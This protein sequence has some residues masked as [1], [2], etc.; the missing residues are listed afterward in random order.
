MIIELYV[1]AYRQGKSGQ[2]LSNQPM[3]IVYME[4]IPAIGSFCIDGVL[5]RNPYTPTYRIENGELVAVE[6]IIQKIV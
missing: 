1:D 3:L 2:K 6:I 4:S 5:Y